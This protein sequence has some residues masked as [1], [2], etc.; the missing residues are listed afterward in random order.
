MS[1]DQKFSDAQDLLGALDAVDRGRAGAV[2]VSVGPTTVRLSPQVCVGLY[3]LVRL[4]GS[5]RG[6]LVLPARTDLST[7]Q[8]AQALSVSR[9]TLRALMDSGDLPYHRVGTH[10]RL[11]LSDVLDLRRR[12]DTAAAADAALARIELGDEARPTLPTP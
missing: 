1:R 6:F 5:G 7:T 8:A 3:D 2:T 11:R 9:R 10:R 4:D 12:R